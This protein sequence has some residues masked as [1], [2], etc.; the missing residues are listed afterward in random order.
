MTAAMNMSKRRGLDGVLRPQPAA[1]DV[2]LGLAGAGEVRVLLV[3]QDSQVP[4]EQAGQGERED[5]LVDD[6]EPREEVA[7]PGKAPPQ[8]SKASQGP[9]K[10]MDWTIEKTT[11][12]P[13][14]ES[15]SSG[16]E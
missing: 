14:P 9:T 15:R 11:R 5:E 7:V 13:E 6:E 3:P 4:A 10:G 16:R 8:M 12:S 1:H 2:A